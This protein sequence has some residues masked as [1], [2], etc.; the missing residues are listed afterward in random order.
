[1]ASFNDFS[2]SCLHQHKE[3]AHNHD[4]SACGDAEEGGVLVQH[5]LTLLWAPTGTKGEMSWLLSL[6]RWGENIK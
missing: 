2:H 4:C 3:G 1:M 6:W 5:L